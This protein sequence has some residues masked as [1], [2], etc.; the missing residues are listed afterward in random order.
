MRLW[1]SERIIRLIPLKTD[2]KHTITN[3]EGHGYYQI[4]A[5]E[6][7]QT[8]TTIDKHRAT[9]YN[10]ITQSPHNTQHNATSKTPHLTYPA[11]GD[12]CTPRWSRPAVWC[13]SAGSRRDECGTRYSLGLVRLQVRKY[14]WCWNTLQHKQKHKV[15]QIN[16]LHNVSMFHSIYKTFRND[17]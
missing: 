3:K 5:I 13:V 15:K 1:R 16:I 8:S 6:P 7:S 17:K 12:W 4:Y 14:I 10:A 11:R 2:I 9:F